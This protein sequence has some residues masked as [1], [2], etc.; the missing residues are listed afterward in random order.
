MH[1]AKRRAV[2]VLIV[3]LIVAGVTV[4][5]FAS[6]RVSTEHAESHAQSILVDSAS[7]QA[8][9]FGQ[10]LSG[11]FQVL[12]ALS[13]SI[14]QMDSPDDASIEALFDAAG[15]TMH[16]GSLAFIGVDGVVRVG[17]DAGVDTLDIASTQAALAGQKGMAYIEE[18]KVGQAG[19]ALSVPCYKD[20]QLI[21]VVSGMHTTDD[22]SARIEGVAYSGESSTFIL[23]SAGKIL[24]PSTSEYFVSINNDTFDFY[25]S[26]DLA[27]DNGPDGVEALR[28]ALAQGEQATIRYTYKGERRVEVFVPLDDVGLPDNDWYVSCEVE[29]AVY[30]SDITKA[31]GDTLFA[32][33]LSLVFFIV[34]V[35]LFVLYDHSSRKRQKI[36]A[37]ILRER[38]QQYGIVLR[39]SGRHVYRY[40]IATGCGY[41]VTSE[42]V[43][44]SGGER[45]HM[46]ESMIAD[47]FVGADQAESFRAFF[48]RI[49]EGESPVSGCFRL[50]KPSGEYAWFN[51]ASTT[52][53]DK[54]GRAEYAI[55]TYWDVTEQRA[56]QERYRKTAAYRQLAERSTIG[57]F[58]LN[59]TKGVVDDCVAEFANIVGPEFSGRYAECLRDVEHLLLDDKTRDVF[60]TR[61]CQSEL[62]AAFE[63]GRTKVEMEHYLALG[64]S[65]P[66]WVS[67]TVEL[68]ANPETNDVEGFM[69]SSNKDEEHRIRQLLLTVVDNDYEFV[70]LIDK[71]T[72]EYKT[73][74]S[75]K[76]CASVVQPKG[77]YDDKL[78][79]SARNLFVPE[80]FEAVKKAFHLPAIIERLNRQ[81]MFELHYRIRVDG[82]LLYKA[83]PISRLEASNRF[84]VMSRIDVTNSVEELQA[85]LEQANQANQ[86]KSE[87][88]SRMSHDIRTPMN[89]IMNLSRMMYDELDD[90]QALVADLGK[91]DA[92]NEFLLGLI[93]DVLDISHIESGAFELHPCVY[94]LSEFIEYIEG[95]I[96]PL[97]RKGGIEFEWKR[98]PIKDDLYVDKVRFNQII[99]NLLSNAVKYTPAGGRV[100]LRLKSSESADGV[101]NM[102]IVVTDTG[103]GMSEEFQRTMF[104]PFAKADATGAYQGTGL[105]LSIVRAI[106]VKMDGTIAVESTPGEGSTFTI[107]LPMLRATPAQLAAERKADK[108]D[109][110]S[111]SHMLSGKRV[112]L[113]EDNDINA[114]ITRRL[115]DKVGVDV[116]VAENGYAGLNTFKSHEVGYYDAILMDVRMPVMDGLETA[117][118]IRALNRPDA[119]KVPIIAMTADA[120][121]EDKKRTIDAGMNA[122]LSK[123]VVP[124]DLYR[125]LAEKTCGTPNGHPAR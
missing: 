75:K 5:A 16:T 3:A 114:S 51:E 73:F 4:G 29:Q 90:K 97:C 50:K 55:I 9:S 1:S 40:E 78:I 43:F 36:D 15:A 122:H 26:P 64:E 18:S 47:G 91:M 14:S 7:E 66:I 109:D 120:F 107:K 82:Q 124:E 100:S 25:T 41:H 74:F 71:A 33:L 70:L 117:S 77:F 80:D 118:A 39:Q 108:L 87:F 81:E 69:Y 98:S 19:I 93:N 30:E 11:Q 17:V 85:A 121:T 86:A 79:E 61:F 32:V 94:K 35:A 53:F 72:G 37:D 65:E 76:D 46:V 34:A 10:I 6:A 106:I 103:I 92:S 67:T 49:D 105:G 8:R 95:I 54:Q 119:K 59:L 104:E 110:L 22:L 123:P 111:Y 63:E 62:L 113:C 20:G 116:D 68:V 31:Q 99:F 57:S 2:A 28:A 125:T 60:Q 102:T 24:V 13:V 58:H 56:A 12:D 101:L 52:V 89:A 83:Y 21:G 112:L 88:L 48:K 96:I 38:D 44:N 27:F 42:D 23:N 84:I 45:P 115:L